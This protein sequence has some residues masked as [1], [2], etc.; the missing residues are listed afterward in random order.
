M[1]QLECEVRRVEQAVEAGGVVVVQCVAPCQAPLIQLAAVLRRRAAV[2]SAPSPNII[3]Q[4]PVLASRVLIV[5]EASC[6]V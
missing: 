4:H 6:L 5:I 1:L 3:Q 2:Q